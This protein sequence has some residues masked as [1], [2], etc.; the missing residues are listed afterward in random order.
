MSSGTLSQAEDRSI[1]VLPFTNLGGSGKAEPLSKGIH[2]DL[3]TRLSN[4]SDLRVKSRTAVGSFSE[5][6]LSMTAIAESLNVRWIV[7][8]GVME[9]GDQVKVNARLVDPHNDSNIWADN[10]LRE[11]TAENFFAIQ[12]DITREIADALQA[13]LTKGEKQRI[14][15]VPTE[16][17]DAYRL[18]VEGRSALNTRTEQGMVK[19]MDYFRQAIRQDSSYALAWSGLADAIGLSLLYGPDSLETPELSRQKAARRALDLDPEL[20]EAQAS[21]GN[22]YMNERKISA[23]HHHL[24]QAVKLKPSYAQAHHW[25][26]FIYI[27]AGQL[28]KS[29]DHL[30]LAVRLNPQHNAARGVLIMVLVAQGEIERA[31][32]HLNLHRGNEQFYFPQLQSLVLYHENNWEKLEQLSLNQLSKDLEFDW[33]W[34]FYHGRIAAMKGDTSVAREYL[35]EIQEKDN[36]FSEAMLYVA[37]DE[38]DSAFKTL[39]EKVE[40]EQWYT[41]QTAAIRYWHSDI[42][43]PIRR[44]PRYEK[45]IRDLN[46]YWGLNP[47]G[48]IPEKKETM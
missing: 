25:L 45:L 34:R 27:T 43:N 7:G 8:G 26:G 20:A 18:Y 19:A 38:H 11:L 13:E 14:T 3:L 35:A 37:L 41:W 28:S 1:A 2:E 4:I 17:L 15:G 29:K 42:M 44:D 6:G 30:S 31:R 21:M 36:F 39:T 22:Y 46:T 40:K 33:L 23:A 32:Q 12:G 10:Y 48:S 24:E 47:D 16:D 9:M 5:K